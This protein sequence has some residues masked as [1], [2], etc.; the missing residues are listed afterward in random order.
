[1]KP[2]EAVFE[3]GTALFADAS[4]LMRRARDLRKELEIAT[5]TGD[6]ETERLTHGAITAGIECGLVQGLEAA[7]RGLRGRAGGDR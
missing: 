5:A 2:L 3:D 7:L 4:A 6:N 1:M